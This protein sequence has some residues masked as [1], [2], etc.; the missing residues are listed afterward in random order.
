[1]TH[2]LHREGSTESLKNDFV[3]VARAAKGI[4]M[5]GAEPQMRRIAEIAFDEGPINAG[6][7]RLRAN[8][9]NGLWNR[10]KALASQKGSHVVLACFDDREKVKRLLQRLKDEDVGISIVIS[11]LTEEVMGMAREIGLKPH[12]INLSLGIRGKKELLPGP[13]VMEFTT[14]CGHALVAAGL[15]KKAIAEVRAGT[16][17]AEEAAR[18]VGLPCVCGLVNL[19]RAAELLEQAK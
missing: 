11:G 18:M 16:K 15:V 6:S 1:M 17:T 12:T 13:E 9:V 8:M 7:S 14:M 10:E 4:N 2:S 3:M 19:T 5:E